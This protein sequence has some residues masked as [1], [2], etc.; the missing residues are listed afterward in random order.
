MS[1]TLYFINWNDSFY[2]PF[3]KKHYGKFCQQIILFDNHSTDNS[4]ELANELGFEVFSFG[5]PGVLSDSDYLE[6]KNNC[7]KG[8]QTDWVIVC[9]AD[10]FVYFPKGLFFHKITDL[11][12]LAC[13]ASLDYTILEPEGYHIYSNNLPEKDILEINT[14]LPDT[15]YNKP[16]MFNP[17]KIKEINFVPGSHRAQPLGEVKTYLSFPKLLHY[18]FIGGPQRLIDRHA[19]Y[20]LRLCAENLE[21]R[22]G[23][24]YLISDDKRKTE[25][26]DNYANCKPVF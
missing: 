14:G 22:W 3:I 25:W 19:E 17:K 5:K 15:K 11:Q 4:V 13:M 2:L 16:I 7:W 20:R 10:E 18:R 23:T 26:L 12:W 9:D 1:S 8:A 6:V 24:Q 21:K